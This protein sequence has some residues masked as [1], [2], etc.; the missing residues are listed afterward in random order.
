MT[1]T[2]HAHGAQAAPVRDDIR[3]EFDRMLAAATRGDVRAIGAIAIAV[4]PL[5]HDEIQ[6]LFE[7][8]RPGI[9]ADVLNELF[10]SMR[11]ARCPFDRGETDGLEWLYR[12][13]QRIA[14]DLP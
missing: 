14:M 1:N 11:D 13:V 6:R 8:T 5:L 12:R 4:S 3:R 9:S 2:A 10:A 7:W